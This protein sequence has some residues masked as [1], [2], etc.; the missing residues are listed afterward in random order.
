MPSVPY[1]LKR[2]EQAAKQETPVDGE[3][4]GTHRLA[5]GTQAPTLLADLRGPEHAFH[6]FR[7]ATHTIRQCIKRVASRFG[8]EVMTRRGRQDLERG[9]CA[10]VDEYVRLLAKTR[11]TDLR[12]SKDR[13]GLLSRLRGAG[14]GEGAHLVTCLASVTCLPG[15]IC[16][17]GVGSGATSALLAN[18]LRGTGKVLWLYDTFAG[19]PAPTADDELINDVDQLGSMAA[20]QGRMRHAQSE[21]LD[22]LRSIGVSA[23]AYRIVAG[24]F[25]DTIADERLPKQVCFAYVDFDFY[26]PIRAALEKL[27]PRLSPGGIIVVD[28][29]GYFSNGAQKALDQFLAAYPELFEI[30]VPNYCHD[31]FAILRHAGRRPEEG[32]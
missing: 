3:G 7:R 15:D 17:F 14:V 23:E 19:L 26:A 31:K 30:E 1:A 11:G 21:V 8:I 25:D 22:R 2:V 5:L 4:R 28:D 10:A 6:A 32:A 16:E 18:E 29:Y 13:I 27:L 9:R 12:E 20:Y 24:L